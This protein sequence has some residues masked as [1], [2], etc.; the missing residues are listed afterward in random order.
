MSFDEIERRF[1]YVP[2]TSNRGALHEDIRAAH[3]AL[4]HVL[5]DVLPDG[6]E[7]ALALTQL[8]D[9]LMWSNAAIATCPPGGI[10]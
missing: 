1:T 10:T 4:A 5:D 9:A 6:R 8:Q 3:K 2:P 7:K